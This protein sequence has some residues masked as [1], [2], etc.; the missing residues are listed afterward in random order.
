MSKSILQSEKECF[1]CGTVLNL[2][3]HHVIF[4]TAGRKISDKLG[5]TVW[6][7]HEAPSRTVR[8]APRQRNRPAV[9]KVRSILL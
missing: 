4:G 2:E 8:A 6:L 3:R 7:C 5:L 9:K 1:M